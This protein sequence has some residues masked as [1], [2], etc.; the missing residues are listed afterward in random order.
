MERGT[1]WPSQ[2]H[3]LGSIM[4][5]LGH[6]HIDILKVDV[7]GS[8]Y[9]FL[10]NA[11]DTGA[12]GAVE[13]LA[14]EWHHFAFDQ[15]YGAGSAPSVNALVTM[16]GAMGLEC[17]FV[18]SLDGWDA[19]ESIYTYVHMH[20]VNYN[21]ASFKRRRAEKPSAVPRRAQRLTSSAGDPTTNAD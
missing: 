9:A 17:W 2:V 15:R 19:A 6:T 20:H 10:E 8:E 3:T 4:R 16:L 12:I 14:L 18:H 1:A 7:E 13:Q 11:I 21:L 5:K